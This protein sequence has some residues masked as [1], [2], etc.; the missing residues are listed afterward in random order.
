M[1]AGESGSEGKGPAW[2]TW[3]E[4]RLPWSAECPI[5]CAAEYLRFEGS[6]QRAVPAPGLD[7]ARSPAGP[8]AAPRVGGKIR[9]FAAT[10]HL[11][12]L[13]LRENAL[14][15]VAQ[16]LTGSIVVWYRLRAVGI[17]ETLCAVI[18]L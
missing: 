9:L 3:R 4:S 15:Y 10:M 13:I 8:G 7:S 5:G 2:R 11:P 1:A 6:A 17:P 16:L 12:V 14:L 18:A